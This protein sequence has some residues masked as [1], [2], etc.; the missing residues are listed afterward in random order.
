MFK[1]EVSIP[2]AQHELSA[3]AVVS[4]TIS[5]EEQQRII[6]R[7]EDHTV[8]LPKAARRKA[9]KLMMVGAYCVLGQSFPPHWYINITAE[10]LDRIFT[11]F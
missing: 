7:I 8:D 11:N 2:C 6:K 1:N 5:E 4:Q 3:E 10:R 9:I